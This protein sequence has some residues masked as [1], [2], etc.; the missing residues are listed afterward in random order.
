MNCHP[1]KI[2]VGIVVYNGVGHI[3]HALDSIIRQTYK[4]IELVIVD[5]G[6]DDGTQ[7]IL[8][9]YAQFITVLICEPDKGIYDA[10]NKVCSIATGDW[11][12]FLGCD[13]VLLD[14]LGKM[15]S[16]LNRADTVYYGD[17]IKRSSGKIYGGKFSKFRLM[18]HNICHQALMY[19]KSVYRKYSY[20][21]E[22]PARADHAYNLRLVG[23]E[24]PFVYTGV[25]VSIYNDE[26]R[27]AS[28]DANFN[29]DQIKLIRASC[30]SMYALIESARR[31]RF[32]LVKR[33]RSV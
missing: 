33:M 18:R 16:L 10:M 20:S 30:G 19:P 29:R 4:N 12:I 15:A 1:P 14:S 2:S 3:R 13:D 11:L 21:L 23:D 32:Q 17:V 9:E 7:A 25:V 31:L 22:Y 26:G 5:G 28:G 27:S 24:V 6:S 8:N